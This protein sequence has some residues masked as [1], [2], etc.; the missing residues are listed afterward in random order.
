MHVMH[1]VLTTIVAQEVLLV[2]VGLKEQ[3]LH[4]VVDHVKETT[5]VVGLHNTLQ[6]TTLKYIL[7]PIRVK[8]VEHVGR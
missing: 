6:L 7:G 4:F 3:R 5:P 1:F 2:M 8:M